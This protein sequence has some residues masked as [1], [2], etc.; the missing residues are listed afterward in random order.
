[1]CAFA[2]RPVAP[3]FAAILVVAGC[4]SQSATTKAPS[5][6]TP[7]TI[8]MEGVGGTVNLNTTSATDANALALLHPIAKVWAILPVVYDSLG[9]PVNKI[10]FLGGADRSGA[11]F[12][13][14]ALM[15]IIERFVD[16]LAPLHPVI[17]QDLERVA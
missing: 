12:L 11:T 6:V 1:M 4:A 2:V 17:K 3:L 5:S 10:E 14:S 8:R 16:G 13:K 9:L 15:A 7:A